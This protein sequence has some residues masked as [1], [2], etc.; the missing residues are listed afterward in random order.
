MYQSLACFFVESE[1]MVV[2]FVVW[3]RLVQTLYHQ[4]LGE[5]WMS[6]L[7]LIYRE[8]G[9]SEVQRGRQAERI[10]DGLHQDSNRASKVGIFS[11]YSRPLDADL[12]LHAEI[13]TSDNNFTIAD[14]KTGSHMPRRNTEQKKRKKT[15]QGAVSEIVSSTGEEIPN[16]SFWS[17]IRTAIKYCTYLSIFSTL[18][19]F[20]SLTLYITPTL[21]RE[22]KAD[23][24][25]DL[26]SPSGQA[27][28]DR[29]TAPNRWNLYPLN[30]YTYQSLLRLSSD[31][32]WMRKDLRHAW[33]Y[34]TGNT[35]C[36]S[37][38]DCE[39]FDSAFDEITQSY[40]LNPPAN[41]ASIFT[42]DCDTSP[43]LCNAW[44]ATPPALIRI[45]SLGHPHCQVASDPWPRLRCPFGTRYIPLPTGA[46][47]AKMLGTYRPVDGLPDAKWQL[48]SLF[49]STCAHEVYVIQRLLEYVGNGGEPLELYEVFGEI[50]AGF[51]VAELY[52]KV[53]SWWLGEERH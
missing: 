24:G 13:P 14:I 11:V 45:E 44:A 51:P 35:T 10:V 6:P 39:R 7:M 47:L 2:S 38:E 33:I 50:I 12:R 26:S 43:F 16:M 41:N 1:T 53:F 9:F 8:L 46:G 28:M 42:L 32:N 15:Q 19:A 29:L 20:L 49:D 25:N 48:R 52:G 30:T 4:R 27:S 37:S 3:L 23:S 31:Q 22:Y 21:Y 5:C 40:Y 34:V 36:S 18:T 17:K